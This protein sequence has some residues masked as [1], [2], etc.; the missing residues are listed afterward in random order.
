MNIEKGPIFVNAADGDKGYTI[1]TKLLEIPKRHSLAPQPI[2]AG[3]SDVH[4][5]SA[6][7]MKAEGAHLCLLN[8]LEDYQ[9]VVDALK[10]VTKLILVID[11]INKR[12]T[13]SNIYDYGKL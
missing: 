6:E 4:T 8:V 10:L 13:K 11:P 1:V 9:S 2:Y 12:I 5:L 7:K 3:I